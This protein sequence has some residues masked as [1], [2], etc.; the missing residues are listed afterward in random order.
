MAERR[1]TAGVTAALYALCGRRCYWP[2]CN[3]PVIRFVADRPVNNLQIA[4]IVAAKRNGPR[5][6]RMPA[7]ERYSFS[8][9]IL[10]C[11]PHHTL[12]DKIEPEKYPIELLREWKARREG[13]EISTLRGLRELTEERLQKMLLDAVIERDR[14]IETALKRFEEMDFEAAHLLR[15]MLEELKDLRTHGP[16]DPDVVSTLHD[17]ATTLRYSVNED[18][19]SELWSAANIL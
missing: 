11:H 6:I 9:L 1:Y 8:N 14:Y 5:F 3:E 16:L 10:L 12:V 19:V 2:D 17:A 15:Q 13:P 7:E 4:H 18:K